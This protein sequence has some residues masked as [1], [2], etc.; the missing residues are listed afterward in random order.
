MTVLGSDQCELS[1]TITDDLTL[2]AENI[3]VLEGP[4]FVGA[5]VG[6]DGAA[7]GGDSAILTIEPGTRIYGGDPQSFLTVSRGSEIIADGT[8]TQPIIFTSAEDLGF[9]SAF[10]RTQRNIHT[11]TVTTD[12]NTAEWGGLV[13][14]GRAPLNVGLEAEG[15][16]DSGLYGGDVAD[17]TSGTLRYVQIKYAGNRV[18]ADDELNGLAFQ[19]VGSGTTVD[20]V[21]VHNGQDDGI[22]FFGGTTDA[23]HLVVSGAGDDSIDW[24]QGWTGD[25]QFALVIQNPAHPEGADRGIE[26]DN[27][28]QDNDALPRA[29]PRMSN[30][31]FIG[32]A[33]GVGDTGIVL[34]RGTAGNYFNTVIS[35]FVDASF[36]IDND[37][38][39]A[40][41]AAGNLTVESFLIGNATPGD[42]IETDD[43]D[44]A[45]DL[46]G[47]L[48]GS[49]NVVVTS[50][51]LSGF[52]N[53]GAE[54]G[55]TARDVSEVD[56]FFD[57]VDFIGA[58]NDDAT[59]YTQ[60]WSFNLNP[61]PACPDVD[62]VTTTADGCV[63]SGTITQDLRLVAGLDYFLDGPV[64]IGAD[65]GADGNAPGG[66]PA[67]ITIDA[68]VTI[69]G[70][71]PQSFMV[72]SR[73]S[74]M[75]AN[76]TANAPITMTADDADASLNTSTALWG[77]LVINGRAP[78][79]VG[80]EA[81]G[82]G[83]S[84]L[85]GG[86]V[87]GD[88]SGSLRF[89]RVVYAGN[90]VNADDELNGVAFQG[91]GNGTVVENLQVH[92]GQDDGVEF[93]GGTVNAK[94]VVVTGAGDDS[95]DWTQG[96]SGKVQ[97]ALVVQNPQHPEGADRGIEA[98]NLEQDNDALP[99]AMP[100]MANMTFVGAAPGV[101][102]TGIV[103]RR[104]TAGNYWNTVIA[105]FVDASFDIDND[106]TYAQVAAGNLTVDS[107]LIGNVTPGDALEQ[108]DDDVA[109]DLVGFINGRGTNVI[110]A[111]SLGERLGGGQF[112]VN[113]ANEAAVAATD[114]GPVDPF[115]TS[116]DF[117][118]AVPDANDD[119][120]QGWTVWLDR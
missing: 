13:L 18:N 90:R 20:F 12:P 47:F 37:A 63:L 105:N 102:D 107:F 101:G 85:Y 103:L 81:E 113:G 59:N 80:L 40:Q 52:I 7:P 50:P 23:K 41:V 49:P 27:L 62:G 61:E 15:E 111:P 73:G 78:L 94:N 17:D 97:F 109:N 39:Y 42:A 118:G 43:D 44:V 89:V 60:G 98:D 70:R 8:P 38:T 5:D 74:K 16:G 93:F 21:H 77:G 66:N 68:G 79:N 72:V 2:T 51:S 54:Q 116:V 32:A 9:A 71:D 104:G 106:A 100:Q 28:E 35:N 4:V 64:F 67:T 53:G 11:G 87:A 56:G 96:W 115:F 57:A 24:T 110:G 14:N 31:T 29:T 114:P 30:M 76:G 26:A 119:F 6:A 82:E 36:D 92:N 108:D 33:P 34:R 83:D 91:V 69:Q 48:L 117:I 88:S 25:V 84:G 45:N 58:V 95:I 3:Y 19:G 112:Y 120:T 99:R 65:V 1:G 55:V 22:E 46:E 75:F 86:D 10:G